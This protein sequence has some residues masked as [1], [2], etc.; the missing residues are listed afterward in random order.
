MIKTFILLYCTSIGGANVSVLSSTF[1]VIYFI[2]CL[3]MPTLSDKQARHMRWVIQVSM[4]VLRWLKNTGYWNFT[5]VAKAFDD[6][7]DYHKTQV[8][9]GTFLTEDLGGYVLLIPQTLSSNDPCG[10]F[11]KIASIGGGTVF[12]MDPLMMHDHPPDHFTC[13][14][15]FVFENSG[16]LDV[17]SIFHDRLY[18]S[19]GVLGVADTA[20]INRLPGITVPF[21]GSPYLSMICFVR[22]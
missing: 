7:F 10:R 14:T 6:T 19:E 4:H 16:E 22:R 1:D 12:P 9:Q 20:A 5:G 21:F 11:S 17:A 18:S 8:K 3:N 15:M 2:Q 13:Y